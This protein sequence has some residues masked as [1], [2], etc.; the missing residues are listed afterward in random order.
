[1]ELF[2]KKIQGGILGNSPPQ[3]LIEKKRK[4]SRMEVCRQQSKM[5][6]RNSA[7]PQGMI[8]A[9]R[10]FFTGFGALY[11]IQ[12]PVPSLLNV[13]MT[14][15]SACNAISFLKIS[16]DRTEGHEVVLTDQIG[17]I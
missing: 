5:G 14:A 11:Q 8:E 9:K 1:M 15:D 10:G 7:H 4:G 12:I 17:G 6:T 13:L 3:K 16:Y 2:F